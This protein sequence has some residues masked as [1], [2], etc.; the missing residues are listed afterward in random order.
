[1]ELY[2]RKRT[3][4]HPNHGFANTFWREAWSPI[5]TVK[6]C[7]DLR[8]NKLRLFPVSWQSNSVLLFPWIK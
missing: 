2:G 3:Q 6:C 4:F 1:M 7:K 8:E 5:A